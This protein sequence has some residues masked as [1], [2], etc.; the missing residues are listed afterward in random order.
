MALDNVRE[1]IGGAIRIAI[2]LLTPFLYKRRARW[3]ATDVEISRSLPGDELVPH[4]KWGYTHAITIRASAAEI[5]PWLVQIG[6]GRGGFYGYEFL[7]NLIGCNIHNADQ[8]IPEFQ[9]LDVGD[10]IRH[11]PKLPHYEVAVVEPSRVL[12][13]HTGVDS[14]T[15]NT[16]ELT[17]T[18]PKKYINAIYIWFLDELANG[19][20]RIIARG[21]Y[22][23]RGFR[24]A[25]G[26]SR[27]FLEPIAFTTSRKMLLGIKER[28]EAAVQQGNE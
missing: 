19:D 25:L 26:N 13:L 21:R 12:V 16:T 27:F 22:G 7:E 18:I 6:Q 3:G 17:N 5:W 2:T 4:N 1:G 23:Y 28:A 10:E 8:I 20:T 9:H 14:K 24:N 15:M 11:H